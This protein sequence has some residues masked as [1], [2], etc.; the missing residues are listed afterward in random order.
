M[1]KSTPCSIELMNKTYAIKC[2][3]H[4]AEKLKMAADKL[5]EQMLQNKQKFKHLDEFENLLLAALHVS[6]ELICCQIQQAQHMD[7]VTRFINSLEHR[8]NST[9]NGD[10]SVDPQTD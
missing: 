3:E 2:P 10:P 4:E 8:I 7:K 5:N 9:V 6:H 1:K